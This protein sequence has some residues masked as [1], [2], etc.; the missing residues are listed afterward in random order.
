MTDLILALPEDVQVIA[1]IL[2]IV[3]L[4]GVLIAVPIT[5]AYFWRHAERDRRAANWPRN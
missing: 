1:C 3:G 5:L 4:T 2:G